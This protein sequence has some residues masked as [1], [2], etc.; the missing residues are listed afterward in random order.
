MRQLGEDKSQKAILQALVVYCAC[1][2][3]C[4]RHSRS[5]RVHMGSVFG[6]F[7]FCRFNWIS[8]ISDDK[9][10]ADEGCANIMGACFAALVIG[11]AIAPPSE[12]TL[13]DIEPEYA[14]E[15]Q[16]EELEAIE[17]VA[18]PAD[19][20]EPESEPE[21]EPIEEEAEPELEPAAASAEPESTPEPP[22]PA[23]EA[24][25]PQETTPEPA[26]P[27]VQEPPPEPATE[28]Q[29]EPEPAAQTMTDNDW[30]NSPGSRIVWTANRTSVVIH[31][32]PDCSNMGNP[33][34][35]TKEAAL[36]R[37]GGG[38]PCQNCW[39]NR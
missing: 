30:G 13:V 5:T 19:E 21:P 28:Q 2:C 15:Y 33:V 7:G 37:S 4:S 31:S 3:V 9:E 20:P 1:C 35:T 8:Y 29:A 14:I 23:Q 27:P 34:Q 6:V 39:T 32:S 17:V 36:N 10:K 18:E 38:R 11:V 26:P 22:A 16:A 12:P 25:T 24:H